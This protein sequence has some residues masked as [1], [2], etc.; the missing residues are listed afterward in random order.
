MD[1]NR[2]PQEATVL[3]QG[4]EEGSPKTL[5][6]S[7]PAQTVSDSKSG[8][9]VIRGLP[10]GK[11]GV[12]AMV[13]TEEVGVSIQSESK[14]ITLENENDTKSAALVLKRSAGISGRI[15][16]RDGAGVQDASILA[17]AS[18]Q[19]PFIPVPRADGCGRAVVTGIP[20][21]ASSVDVL[22]EA[23]GIGRRAT[24]QAIG[25]VGALDI[26]LDP[27][28]N[29]TLVLADSRPDHRKVAIYHEGVSDTW[30]DL[31]R[32]GGLNGAGAGVGE[33]RAPLMAPG[34]YRACDSASLQEDLKRAAKAP[35]RCV[36]GYLPPAGEPIW[37]SRRPGDE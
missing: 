20:K 35:D 19:S 13:P 16:T 36:E 9:F 18:S 17:T 29:G 34:T 8:K 21:A 14:T 3:A 12:V 27:D 24:R 7:L 37:W 33:L 15:R 4:L 23:V 6:S 1:E 30:G 26:V 28:S 5:K 32:W 10:P 2:V 22:V 31:A 25:P 11:Y